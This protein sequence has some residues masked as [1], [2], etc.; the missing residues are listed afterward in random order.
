MS[1]FRKKDNKLNMVLIVSLAICLIIIAWAIILP[2]GFGNMANSLMGFVTS[3]FGWLYM[4]GVAVFLF[5]CLFMAVSKYG[6]ITLGKDDD[7]P[8][9]STLSWFS[10]LFSSG[11][12]I[13][14]IF[15]GVAEPIT[16]FTTANGE[17]PF[18]VDNPG[19]WAISKSLLHWCLHP[20]AIFCV[21]GLGLAYMVFR[22]D[23]PMLISS[24]FEPALG[25]KKA[26]KWLA[27]VIDI[28]A[29]FAT[30]A[31]V[32]TSLGLGTMQINGGLNELFG[33]PEN[34]LVRIIII[35]V[36]SVLFTYTA[37]VGI[38]K[39][40]SIVADI[41]MILF[42]A[43][44][45]LC[46]VFGPTVFELNIMTEGIG[47]YLANIIPD[48]FAIG[49]FNEEQNAWYSN[50]TVFYWAWWV[51]WAPFCGCF[52]ARI[53][54]GRTVKE[55]IAGVL[56]VPALLSVIWFAIMGGMGINLGEKI[57]AI[58][59]QNS[60]TAC[61]VVFLQYPLGKIICG[62]CL[63]LVVTFFV[64]SANSATFVLG[65]YSCEGDLQPSGRIKT[66]WGVVEAAFAL[67]LL[68][69]TEDG[70]GM[71]QTTSIAGAFPFLLIMLGSVYAILRAFN[72]E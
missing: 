22:K 3:K 38:E 61:F 15:W 2:E 4:L 64:T 16:H 30:V 68:I 33:I 31:G 72:E 17:N 13:G 42:V 71:M 34:N 39:G 36:I 55:F 60:A 26:W 45:V 14:L 69:A 48:S 70:L 24:I 67:F 56:I 62:I 66:I 58:A 65:M 51:A 53:S 21:I 8:E 46:F 32:S 44:M 20:W 50:W 10:M 43:I 47:S 27:P 23:K 18:N 57:C 40:I 25:D 19:L 41:N 12:G 29:V 6:K 52:I 63:L 35:V 5:F 1:I 49:A 59:S 7:K 11:M 28:F 9:Y 54:R 37:A